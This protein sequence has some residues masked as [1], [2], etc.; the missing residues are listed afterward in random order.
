MLSNK[1]V[2]RVKQAAGWGLDEGVFE[3]GGGELK[4]NLMILAT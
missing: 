3:G 1:G 4:I 2:G